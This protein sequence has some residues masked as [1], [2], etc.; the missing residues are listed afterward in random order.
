MISGLL[1]MLDFT[2]KAAVQEEKVPAEK[3]EESPLGLSFSE[4][5]LSFSPEEMTKAASAQTPSHHTSH[6]KKD[7]LCAIKPY[8]SS[9]KRARIDRVLQA[10]E[11]V[12][13]LKGK[14]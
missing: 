7:I 13:V 10:A 3:T 12:F 5:D 2:Q 9:A 6:R 8:V 11:L 4:D 14:S 1:S